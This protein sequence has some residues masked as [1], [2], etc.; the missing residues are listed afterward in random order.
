MNAH[1][2]L[3]LWTVALALTMSAVSW[4]FAIASS[5]DY[6]PIERAIEAGHL[7]Q[8]AQMLQQRLATAPDDYQAQML[9][10]IVLDE[11]KHPAEAVAHFRRAVEL[12][13]QS[14]AAHLNLGKHEAGAGDPAA[15]IQ[16]FRAAIR[17][18]PA[19][20]AA[21]SNLGLAL[22]SQG[23]QAPALPELE[24]AAELSPRALPAWLDLFRC[25][26]ALKQFTAARATSRKVLS[27][28]PG[29][30]EVMGRLG[31]LQAQAGDYRGAIETLKQAIGPDS[32]PDEVRYNL[33]LAYFRAGD[34]SNA[35]E[36]LES[37]NRKKETA[38]VDDL[39]GEIYEKQRDYIKAVQAFQ[40][41]AEID[42]ASEEYRFDFV[43]E[44]LAHR[45]DSA[46][47]LVAERALDDFPKSMRLHLALGVARFAVGSFDSAM[48]DFRQTAEIFPDAALPLSFLALASDA[49]G[50]EI[51]QTV[52]LVKTYSARHSDEFWPYYYLGHVALQS[53][54]TS[55]S[56]DEVTSA[57]GLLERSIELRPDYPDS[58]LELGNAY[59]A[60]HQW[61]K[62]IQ[63]YEKAINLKPDLTE[64]HY[65]L[66]RAYL[67]IGDRVRAQRQ[68]EIHQRLQRQDDLG[69]L[70]RRQVSVFLYKLRD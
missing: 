15:A 43:T 17:L 33:G 62:A 49:T 27:L 26:L 16:E 29:S 3:Q 59:A 68:T 61:S 28:A 66:S 31:A 58:H 47:I 39:L 45:T 65:K 10:G 60:E 53:A 11:Q 48:E 20:S 41:S 6:T 55:Q 18:D 37:L 4:N 70:R 52:A 51:P 63:Q 30:A 14:A 44:L 50:K 36:T 35:A 13:P 69:D 7:E 1:C 32:C 23:Q 2:R 42:P 40:K 57:A 25:Q 24:K 21:H 12:Q 67:A 38:E 54:R 46:A 22:I 56:P 34:L 19:D 5:F 64:A 8:A 9:L